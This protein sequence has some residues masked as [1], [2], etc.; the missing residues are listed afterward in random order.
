ME[1]RCVR[2]VAEGNAM[3]RMAGCKA[4]FENLFGSQICSFLSSTLQVLVE[5]ELPTM[6][7]CLGHCAV[8][9]GPE[10]EKKDGQMLSGLYPAR[11]GI[12][13]V[14]AREAKAA[15][16]PRSVASV[17]RLLQ[18]LPLTSGSPKQARANRSLP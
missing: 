11:M 17:T 14:D 3:A 13:V 2:K 15:L 9:A 4:L 6:Y 7:V 12:A 1:M 16:L 18:R 8:D 10:P 5:L